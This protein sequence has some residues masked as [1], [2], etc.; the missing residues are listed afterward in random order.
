MEVDV[1][2]L[3]GRRSRTR[4]RG[5]VCLQALRRGMTH[6]IVFDSSGK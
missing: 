6:A 2:E 3:T 5:L 1:I 4:T